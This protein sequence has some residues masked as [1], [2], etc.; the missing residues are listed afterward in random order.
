MSSVRPFLGKGNDLEHQAKHLA[1]HR[2]RLASAVPF[3]RW[4]T[5]EGRSLSRT[6]A[7]LTRQLWG[8]GFLFLESVKCQVW[9]S[10]DQYR[11][12]GAR[13]ELPY[14]NASLQCRR[15]GSVAQGRNLP[16]I[17]VAASK[18]RLKKYKA[19]NKLLYNFLGGMCKSLTLGKAHTINSDKGHK[20]PKR[21]AEAG[22]LGAG[23]KDVALG[24][25]EI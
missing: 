21:R 12:H 10:E 18:E 7:V 8:P 11:G 23:E 19:C 13:K 25:Y 24:S 15:L 9:T 22:R 16:G 14:N 4:G 2:V 17:N 3:Y 6:M 1:L 5:E 20:W